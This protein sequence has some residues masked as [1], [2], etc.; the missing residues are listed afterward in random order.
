MKT[1]KGRGTYIY[2][3]NTQVIKEVY[4]GK[5]FQDG[6]EPVMLTVMI[7]KPGHPKGTISSSPTRSRE[8]P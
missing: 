4:E 7:K 6:K 3:E 5:E 2:P 1:I 8:C